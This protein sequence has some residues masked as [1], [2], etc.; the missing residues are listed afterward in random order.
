MLIVGAFQDI[1][2]I[3]SWLSKITAKSSL[4]QSEAV[5]AKVEKYLD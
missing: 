1:F 5:S 4:R 2:V 3:V